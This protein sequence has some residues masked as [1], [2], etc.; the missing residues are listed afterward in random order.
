[1]I[2]G[3]QQP[4]GFTCQMGLKCWSADEAL[5]AAGADIILMDNLGPQMILGAQQPGGFTCQM[6]LKCWSA[7]E[8]L[9]AAGADIILMDNLGPQAEVKFQSHMLKAKE[10]QLARDREET[11]QELGLQ[12]KEPCGSSVAARGG[13]AKCDQGQ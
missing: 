3:A 7:D 9:A 12:E 6:G 5:A 8:A 10:E 2:L 11:W 4:G 1:M 13:D